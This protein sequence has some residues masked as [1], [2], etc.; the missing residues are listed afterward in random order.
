MGGPVA[1][2]GIV[3]YRYAQRWLCHPETERGLHWRGLTLKLAAWPVYLLGTILAVFRVDVPYIPTAKEARRGRFLRLAW[4]HLALAGVYALTL[5]WTLYRRLVLTPEGALVLSSEAVWGMMGFA[6][7]AFLMVSGG[8]YGAW[9]AR[10]L[11]E[12]KAWDTVVLDDN[13]GEEAP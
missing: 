3:L 9:E 11:P 4:P 2:L 6:T 13:K 7:V 10:T 8:L 1:L 5:G 12:G